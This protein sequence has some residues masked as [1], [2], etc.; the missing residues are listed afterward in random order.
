[1]IKNDPTPWP[2]TNPSP[3]TMFVITY[4]IRKDMV[5]KMCTHKFKPTLL[6]FLTP[7]LI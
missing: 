6:A 3:Q 7:A 2:K 4:Q 5:T 1:M